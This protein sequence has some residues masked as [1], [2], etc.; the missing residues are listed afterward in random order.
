VAVTLLPVILAT[1]GSAWTGRGWRAI[2]EQAVLGWAR[3]VYRHRW[4]PLPRP[5][6]SSLMALSLH[7]GNQTRVERRQAPRTTLDDADPRRHARA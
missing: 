5:R 3:R 4:S 6:S 1:A 7:L 2:G